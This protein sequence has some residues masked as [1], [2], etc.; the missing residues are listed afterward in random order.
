MQLKLFDCYDIA[1]SDFFA[2]HQTWFAVD[3]DDPVRN[4]FFCVTAC[5]CQAAVF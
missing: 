5:F 3:K 2:P 4:D 1:G